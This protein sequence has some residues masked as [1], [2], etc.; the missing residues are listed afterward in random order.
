MA[1]EINSEHVSSILKRKKTLTHL[2]FW[3]NRDYNTKQLQSRDMIEL[4]K[5][6]IQLPQLQVLDLN[7]K[8]IPFFVC[9]F[10]SSIFL[11]CIRNDFLCDV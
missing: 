10:F 7:C 5:L 9:D 6:L 2:T 8:T 1:G 3:G 4:L 11:A